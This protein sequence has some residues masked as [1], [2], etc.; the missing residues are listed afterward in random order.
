MVER[1]TVE[2]NERSSDITGRLDDACALFKVMKGHGCFP[3]A[4]AYT[5]LLDG[6]CRFGS[7]EV[8]LDLLQEMENEGGDCSSNVGDNQHFDKG[9]LCTEGH[10]E[11]AYKLIDKVVAGGSVSNGECNSSLVVSLLRIKKLVEPEKLFRGMLASAMKLDGLASNTMIKGLCLDGLA[12]DGFYLYNEID[13]LGFLSSID[14]DIYSILLDGLCRESHLANCARLAQLMV[15]R[16]IQL[17]ALYVDDIIEH[18]ENSGENEL[19]SHSLQYSDF[20]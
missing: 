10:L 13:K 20:E 16:R 3:N 14:L 19:A 6:V 15:E 17:K 8:A 1:I 12:L 9:G 11:E 18:L 2:Y 7:L 4:V 5:T